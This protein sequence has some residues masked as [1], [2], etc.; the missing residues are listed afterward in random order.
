MNYRHAFHAGNHADVL[1]HVVLMMLV[2]HF[3]KKPAPF[4]YLD[5]HAG[6]G[7]Y[8]LSL[9]ESQRS[10]EYKQ[11]IGRLLEIPD[12]ALPPEVLDYVRLVRECAGAGRSAITAYPGSPSIVARLRRPADRMVLVEAHANEVRSL[13]NALGRQKSVSVVEGDGYA[14]VKAHTPPRENR[15]LV[16]IDPPYES[17]VEFDA[18]LAALE[19]GYERWPTGTY[20]VWHPLT[21]RAGA[22][23]FRRELERSGL[24]KVLGCTVSVMPEDTPVGLHG[25][26]LV[27]VNPPWQLDERLAELLPD[28]HRLLVP[29]GAGGTTVEWLVGEK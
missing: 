2:E 11:G 26:G 5:T 13:R 27:I 17:D 23:R 20:C 10:G 7:T 1:K 16:L 6:A 22:L 8:D 21:E 15:G 25:S 18:V 29:D 9:G 14:A 3:K 12:V 28:L 4:F 24:R 19:T